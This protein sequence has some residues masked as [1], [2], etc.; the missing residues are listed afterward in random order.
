[1][2]RSTHGECVQGRPCISPLMQRTTDT[3]D[4]QQQR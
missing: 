1:V 3:S 2:Q 4:W